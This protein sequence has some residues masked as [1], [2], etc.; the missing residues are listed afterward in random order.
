MSH[1]IT[2]T[3]IIYYNGST[4]YP[5]G[6]RAENFLNYMKQLKLQSPH[7][8][9]IV[10]G[11]KEWLDILGYSSQAVYQLP[12]YVQEFLY[13]AEKQGCSELQQINT[14]MMKEHYANLKSRNNQRQ[15]GGLSNSY[16][17][18]HQQALKKVL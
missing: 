6:M 7:Y 15:G 1:P 3:S 4:A 12:N 13:Y 9:Y 11:F 16:L 5:N 10:Q 8:R 14:T 17:N 18:K 2:K